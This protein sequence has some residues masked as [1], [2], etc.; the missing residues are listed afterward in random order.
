MIFTW[1]LALCIS[2]NYFMTVERRAQSPDGG[3]FVEVGIGGGSGLLL[4]HF[5]LKTNVMGVHR[6]PQEIT[7][8][9]GPG[10]QNVCHLLWRQEH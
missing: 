3:D 1:E 9:P 5:P 7:E 10:T 8:A 6:V 2:R 4:A